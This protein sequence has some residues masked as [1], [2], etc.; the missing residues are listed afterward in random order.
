MKNGGNMSTALVPAAHH[1][2]VSSNNLEA[3]I[4]QVNSIA[5]LD[6][7]EERELAQHLQQQGDIDA[8]QKLIVSNLRFVVKIARGYMGY[9]L[10]L[11]DLIQEG[12]IGLMK[13]VK[14]FSPDHEVRLISYAVHW[15]KAEIHE[16]VI[17]NWKIVKIATTKAQRK[18]F[19]KLRSNK[20]RWLV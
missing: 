10:Q 17:R 19:F 11:N 16:F 5:M 3:Y 14:R 1:Y 15:I 9:G 12:N 20:K 4:R 7:D 18:L 13:A 6:A 8:A 2:P